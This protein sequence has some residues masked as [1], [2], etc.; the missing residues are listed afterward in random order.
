[1]SNY[2]G[3]GVESSLILTEDT[4]SGTG[5]WIPHNL[6]LIATVGGEG[7]VFENAESHFYLY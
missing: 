3:I 2:A 4:I 7:A 1:M 6:R 5:P